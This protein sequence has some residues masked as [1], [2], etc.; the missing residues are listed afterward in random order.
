MLEAENKRP[1]GSA[2]YK[3]YS[4]KFTNQYGVNKAPVF[5]G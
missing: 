3:Y 5:K 4:E 2:G 1:S